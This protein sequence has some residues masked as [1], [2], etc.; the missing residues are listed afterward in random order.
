MQTTKTHFRLWD[1]DWHD[2]AYSQGK[3]RAVCMMS[4][5]KQEFYTHQLN[6][7]GLCTYLL[8]YI[9]P[10]VILVVELFI[11]LNEVSKILKLLVSQVN[12]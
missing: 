1:N 5:G 9:Y 12:K 7:H 4:N 6:P 2:L 11:K 10:N 8:M 3:S